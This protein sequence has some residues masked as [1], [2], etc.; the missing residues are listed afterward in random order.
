MNID[1]KRDLMEE[2][3][4][5]AAENRLIFRSSGVFTL[6]VMGAPGAGKTT[7][8]ERM[9]RLMQQRIRAAVIEGDLATAKDARRIAD[10][11]VPVVQINTDGGCHLDALMINKVLS[12]FYLDDIDLLMIEN[13]G[14]LVCPASFDLGE[15]LRMVVMSIAAGGD[16]PSKY[17]TA[18]LASDIA[19]LNKMD[20]LDMVEIDL[21]EMKKEILEIKPDIKIFQTC[22]R[23]GE[24]RGVD[25]LAEHLIRLAKSRRAAAE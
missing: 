22:C 13:V 1:I 11:G 17:P 20:M 15:D 18:F 25:E 5:Y 10:C 23:K 12:G 6:N 2:N 24:V 19:V 9:L 8:L 4:A 21:A 16:K 7:L 3:N 14:N